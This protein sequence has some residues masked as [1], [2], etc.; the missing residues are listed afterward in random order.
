MTERNRSQQSEPES[1]IRRITLSVFET[2]YNL[3]CRLATQ[4]GGQHPSD[5]AATLLRE[6]ALSRAE[7]LE[8]LGDHIPHL[9]ILL[10]DKAG[11]ESEQVYDALKRIAAR[12]VKSPTESSMEELRALCEEEG[13]TVE[14]IMDDL[15]ES[16]AVP[17]VSNSGDKL[18]RAMNWIIEFMRGKDKIPSTAAFEAAKH[19]GFSQRTIELAKTRLCVP[20]RKM[21]GGVWYWINEKPLEDDIRDLVNSKR[22]AAE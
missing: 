1:R 2:D 16:P 22:K 10:K 12:H 17:V 3:I 20:S 8:A 4:D 21:S 15:A 11:R 9:N 19:D 7:A 5:Y 14:E 18:A 13:V 6:A